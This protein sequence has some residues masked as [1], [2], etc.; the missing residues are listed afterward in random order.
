MK[1]RACQAGRFAFCDNASLRLSSLVRDK[2]GATGGSIDSPLHA[3]FKR[4]MRLI[5]YLQ[6]EPAQVQHV[7]A[8]A[9]RRHKTVAVQVVAVGLRRQRGFRVLEDAE[10]VTRSC[11]LCKGD[12]QLAANCGQEEVD[13]QNLF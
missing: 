12:C 13:A 4:S 10:P 3:Q 6:Q 8:T 11:M 2:D 1:P 7:L 9:V 5:R